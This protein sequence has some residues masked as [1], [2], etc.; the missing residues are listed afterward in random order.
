MRT[1]PYDYS[2]CIPEQPDTHCKNCKRWT[3]QPGQTFAESQSFILVANS[4]SESCSYIP[5]SLLKER[6]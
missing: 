5:I 3:D 4:K 6:P 2:R 1:L